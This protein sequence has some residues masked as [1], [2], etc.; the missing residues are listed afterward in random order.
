[1]PLD[2]EFKKHLHSSRA[3]LRAQLEGPWRE[4]LE[5]HITEV[6]R[7]FQISAG[8]YEKLV[9][10]DAGSMAIA[11]TCRGSDRLKIE[12]HKFGV[13]SLSHW[14]VF[15][16][17]SVLRSLLPGVAHNFMAV[18]IAQLEGGAFRAGFRQN[19]DA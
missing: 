16:I 17:F 4:G 9:A 7:T 8:F 13:R 15:I 2:P 6:R 11:A 19:A 14:L 5:A 12:F 18:G 3:E 10:P 1:M